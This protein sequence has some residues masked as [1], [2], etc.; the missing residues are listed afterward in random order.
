MGDAAGDIGPGGLALRRQELG[1][2]VEGD[3]KAADLAAVLLGVGFGGDANEQRAH[4]V[5]AS[6]LDLGLRQPVRPPG[7]LL[8]EPGHFGGDFCKVLSDR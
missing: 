6:D 2:V 7:G 5:G 3:D 1:D 4:A 8:Q